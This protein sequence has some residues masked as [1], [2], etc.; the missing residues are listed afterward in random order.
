MPFDLILAWVVLGLLA[1]FSLMMLWLGSRRTYQQKLVLRFWQGTGLPM[2]TDTVAAA[3]ARRIRTRTNGM[4][5]GDLIGIAVGAVVLYLAPSIAS[6]TAIWLLLAPLVLT[7]LASGAVVASLSQSLFQRQADVARFARPT[8]VAVHDYVSPKRMLAAPVFIL[9]AMALC[10][11]GFV[12]AFCDRIDVGTFMGSPA[13]PLL[14]VAL[15]VFA[16]SLGLERRVLNEP[17]P[18]SSEL[19]LAWDDAFRADTF[20]GLR[21][22][23]AMIAWLAVAAAGLTV[24]QA[25]DALNATSRSTGLG[26]QLFTWGFLATIAAFSFG[27]AHNYFRFRLWPELTTESVLIKAA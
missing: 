20:R 26:S 27:G 25:V 3:A 7:G 23:A 12:L 11:L 10:S 6:P 24:L 8:A 1:L 13:L 21:M 15:I 2:G 4:M 14:A 9:I 22:F 19:E 16:I 17:Q 5:I 18:A